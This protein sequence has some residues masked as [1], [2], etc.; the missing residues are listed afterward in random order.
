MKFVCQLL[1]ILLISQFSSCQKNETPSTS[2]SNVTPT[3][4]KPEPKTLTQK[5]KSPANT[6][7]QAPKLT[8]T[9]DGNILMS[10][11]EK[12][13]EKEQALY[14]STLENN[15]WSSPQLIAKSDNWFINWADIPS[16]SKLSDGSLAAHWL[17]KSGESTYAYDINI[18]QSFDNGKTWSKPILPHTDGT[19]TE[20]GFVS[21]FPWN[22]DKFGAIWLDGRKIK[23]NASG[24]YNEE[25]LSNEM[26]LR[27]T[28]MDKSGKL[29]EET[30]LDE[31]V[32][33]C[34]P[35]SVAI[36]SKGAIAVYRDRSK[37]EFRDISFVRYQEGKWSQPKTLYPDKWQIDGCPVNGPVVVAK[38]ELVA[39]AWFSLAGDRAR[40]Q[41]IFSNN[42]G[43]T[44]N[45]PITIAEGDAI[46]RVDLTMLDDSSVLITWL[47][48][49]KDTGSL[50][51]LRAWSDGKK[52]KPIALLETS[53]SRKSG[54]PKIVSLNN[55]AIIA[56]IDVNQSRVLTSSLN[57][58]NLQ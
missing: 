5:I 47:A 30:A 18:V 4:P 11:L 54:I 19:K 25:D 8:K 16:I 50:N 13:G 31:R 3:S 48:G 2:K 45:E 29:S 15:L 10:W 52:T 51:I 49:T 56:W 6:N 37:E 38:D 42:S 9:P 55:Q 14:F 21:I 27:F 22:K 39:V 46:G 23:V 57:I 34:C 17:A 35:T 1:L 36:T 20:H 32:C 28:A 53:I 41:L 44:F 40:V 24:D 33:D 7:S 58:N 12:I 43:E 26:T